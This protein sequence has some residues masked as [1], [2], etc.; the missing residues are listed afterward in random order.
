M[1]MVAR[2]YFIYG[3]DL[4]LGSEILN[5][6]ER[7]TLS[8]SLESVNSFLNLSFLLAGC[9]AIG[10]VGAATTLSP[11][12]SR[13]FLDLFLFNYTNVVFVGATEGECCTVWPEARLVLLSEWVPCKL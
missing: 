1:E 8:S 9:L 11:Y 4:S 2:N 10:F 3:A 12:F 7:T 13:G 5:L 6:E